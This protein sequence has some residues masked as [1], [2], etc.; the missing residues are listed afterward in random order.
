MRASAF[1]LVAV[2]VVVAPV[3]SA[4]SRWESVVARRVTYLGRA[5]SQRMRACLLEVEYTATA[6][7]TKRRSSGNHH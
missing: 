3:V 5:A 6:T 7:D 4:V 2:L 1:H